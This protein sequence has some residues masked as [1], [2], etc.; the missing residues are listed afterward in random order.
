MAGQIRWHGCLADEA[1]EGAGGRES[2]PEEDVCRGT[3]QS[4]DRPGG[5]T[6]KKVVKPSQRKE[7]AR[8]AKLGIWPVL[9]VLA[10]CPR[11]PLE[12]QAGL[13]GTGAEPADQAPEA[14]DPGKAAAVVGTGNDQRVLVHGF[15]ARSTVGRP[16]LPLV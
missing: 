8:K 1:F 11:I 5:G 16:E 2:S 9:P 12:S 15:H 6:D 3:A 14:P 7:M 4:G 10:Q 13:P